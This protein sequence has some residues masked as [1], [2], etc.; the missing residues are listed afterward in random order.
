[1]G[2]SDRDICMFGSGTSSRRVIAFSGSMRFPPIL[3]QSLG[4]SV[5][6]ISTYKH[7]FASPIDDSDLEEHH[8]YCIRWEG[9]DREFDSFVNVSVKSAFIK[10][11][12]SHNIEHISFE[13]RRIFLPLIHLP[14]PYKP[15]LP[16][17]HND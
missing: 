16:P 10:I 7:T 12:F 15:S 17:L 1:M 4:F 8:R 11:N 14:P 6:I 2:L 3:R 5:L 9:C 13:K